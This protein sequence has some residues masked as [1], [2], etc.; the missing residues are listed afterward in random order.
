[1]SPTLVGPASAWF[2]LADIFWCRRRW[3]LAFSGRLP[4]TSF[5]FED[6]SVD[7]GTRV[8]TVHAVIRHLLR[9]VGVDRTSIV[10]VLHDDCTFWILS[11]RVR[12]VWPRQPPGVSVEGNL[13]KL[14]QASCK[15]RHGRRNGLLRGRTA[16]IVGDASRLWGRPK[17]RSAAEARFFHI[18]SIYFVS[19]CAL[20][21]RRSSVKT[22]KR[23]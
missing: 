23:A 22:S 6:R 11:S 20:V 1:M 7:W 2:Q 14:R 16:A 9:V 4:R 12:M 21:V 10:D 18:Y 13:P 5:Q 15:L 8:R 19:K 17:G 3:R